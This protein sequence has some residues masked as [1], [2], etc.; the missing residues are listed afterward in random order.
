VTISAADFFT[1]A[2]RTPWDGPDTK[3]DEAFDVNRLRS[4]IEAPEP[5]QPDLDVTLALMDL[6]R[7]DPT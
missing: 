4:L 3:L 6:V 1:I 7:D 5:G 2:P